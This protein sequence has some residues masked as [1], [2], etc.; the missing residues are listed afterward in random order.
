[1]RQDALLG[2]GAWI[3]VAGYLCSLLFL[4][5]RGYRARKEASLNDFYL[6]G[7]SFGFL[8]LFLTLYATQYSGNSLFGFTG[9]AYRMGWAWMMSVHF[10]VAI[11]V[12]Y[13]TYAPQLHRLAAAHQFVTPADYLRHRFGDDKLALVGSAVMTV[14]LLNYLLAQ[15]MAMGRALQGLAGPEVMYAYEVGVTALAAI[16]LIYGSL[17]GIR[18]VAWTDVIQGLVLLVGFLLLFALLWFRFGSPEAIGDLINQ[19]DGALH[20]LPPN[21]NLQRQWLSYVLIVGL[22]GALYPQAVQRIFAARSEQVLRRSL[23][24]TAAM[25]FLTVLVSLVA[26]IYAIALVPGLQ[27]AASD[28]VLTRL[29]RLLLEDSAATYWLVVLLFSAL[30]AA[31]M[32]TADSAL[33]T[34]SSMFTSDWYARHMRPDADQKTLTRIAKRCS[35]L[36]LAA[37]VV[38][39]ILLKDRASL[40]AILDRKFDLL[41]QLVPAF[42]FGIRWKWLRPDAVLVGMAAGIAIALLIAFVPWSLVQGGKL[43]GFHP[44]IYGLIVNFGLAVTWSLSSRYRDSPAKV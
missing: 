22:G 44:G 23:A 33:L 34:L 27:G 11:V 13:L 3:F 8:V 2:P 41:V 9:A 35:M 1:M 40:V 24:A 26:G 17:G 19:R 25:P 38:L 5:W 32:S 37:L 29:L 10:M 16:I 7:S 12:V 21:A 4:G 14:A 20:A 28:Q 30:L 43:F 39:A 36:L 15:L 42:I 6:A 18:A 31:I